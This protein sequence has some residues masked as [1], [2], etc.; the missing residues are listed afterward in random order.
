MIYK[1][2]NDMKIYYISSN[3]TKEIRLRVPTFSLVSMVFPPEFFYYGVGLT[4]LATLAMY[5]E[6]SPNKP[7]KQKNITMK[8]IF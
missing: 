5:Y 8:N 3:V 4:V 7:K 1:G 6:A 2:C